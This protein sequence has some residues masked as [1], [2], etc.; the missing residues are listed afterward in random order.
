[1][2]RDIV[3]E[4]MKYDDL[5]QIIHHDIQHKCGAFHKALMNEA[6]LLR[7][8]GVPTDAIFQ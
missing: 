5:N 4:Y 7:E 3:D 6:L 8:A 1:M 2:F